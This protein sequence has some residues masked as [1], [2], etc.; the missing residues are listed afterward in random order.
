[1]TV[2]LCELA[3]FTGA[4]QPLMLKPVPLSV[5]CETVTVLFPVLVSVKLCDADLPAAS[6][7]KFTLV[8]PTASAK[9]LPAAS[10][11]TGKDALTLATLVRIE[12]VP[13]NVPLLFGVTCTVK[14]LLVPGFSKVEPVNPLMLRPLPLATTPVTVTAAP[15]SLA[16]FSVCEVCVPTTVEPKLILDGVIA[17][18]GS[19]GVTG[20]VAVPRVETQPTNGIAA[21]AVANDKVSR[22]LALKFFPVFTKRIK[23]IR[24]TLRSGLVRFMPG[25][26]L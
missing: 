15:P 20:D 24:L 26:S 17:R 5:T 7:P 21:S 19:K 10:P 4:L 12:T 14:V 22:Q 11:V 23:P 6:V 3:R 1:L 16:I 9:S 8:G 13:L 18:A 25:T 2:K